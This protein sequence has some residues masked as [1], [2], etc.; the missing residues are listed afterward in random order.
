MHECS[1]THVKCVDGILSFSGE[2]CDALHSCVTVMYY[3]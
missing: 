2:L 1:A 3:K